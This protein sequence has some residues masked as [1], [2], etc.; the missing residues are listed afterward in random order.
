M[1]TKTIAKVEYS[2]KTERPKVTFI[3]RSRMPKNKTYADGR[4]VV[5]VDF[6][7]ENSPS[8]Y[9]EYGEFSYAYIDAYVADEE[10]TA[11]YNYEY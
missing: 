6:Y 7:N 5:Y 10:G 9:D 11:I 2:P 1:K 4:R 8:R 3:H